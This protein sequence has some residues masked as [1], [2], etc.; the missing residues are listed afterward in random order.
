MYKKTYTSQHFIPRTAS[1]STHPKRNG[2]VDVLPPD[3]AEA[4]YDAAQQI[5]DGERRLQFLKVERE[6]AVEKSSL[7][8]G[9]QRLQSKHGNDP[10]KSSS[11]DSRLR[12][13]DEEVATVRKHISALRALLRGGGVNTFDEAFVRVAR[14]ELAQ[15]VF[16]TISAKAHRVLAAAKSTKV[17]RS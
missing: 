6:S 13:I 4:L 10:Q 7:A 3:A 8:R 2:R 14:A 5:E 12:A 11:L 9:V 17:A 15:D 16:E 1:F